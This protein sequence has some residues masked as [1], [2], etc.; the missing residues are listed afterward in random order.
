[1][2]AIVITREQLEQADEDELLTLVAYGYKPA[3]AMLN[4]RKA[5]KAAKS[6]ID[7]ADHP[8]HE[9]HERIVDHY[10]P[11]IQRVMAQSI[12][13]IDEAVATAKRKYDAEQDATKAT[14]D[15]PKMTAAQRAA[16]AA[17]EAH[18]TVNSKNL[19]ELMHQLL[20][21]G[22]VSAGHATAEDVGGKMLWGLGEEL[23]SV[24][25]ATWEPGWAK[26]ADL[27]RGGGLARLLETAKATV[28]DMDANTLRWL[29]NVLA[30]GLDAGSSSVEIARAMDEV[31][32]N[33]DRALL[34][35]NTEVSRAMSEATVDTYAANDI[36]QWEW[37]SEQDERTCDFC[38]DKDGQQYDVGGDDPRPPEHPRCRCV[39]LPVV[40]EPTQEEMDAANGTGGDDT[41][42]ADEE[43]G[44][45]KS[46]A[47]EWSE[48]D[49]PRGPDGRFGATD[50]ETTA[51][52]RS[53]AEATI[54]QAQ[55][56]KT[57]DDFAQ[58]AVTHEQL[59]D[60]H[61]KEAASMNRAA[62]LARTNGQR[63]TANNLERTALEHRNAADRHDDAASRWKAA[64]R[65]NDASSARSATRDAYMRTADVHNSARSMS[66][67][68]NKIA[69]SET[70]ETSG[71]KSAVGPSAPAGA[72]Y[73]FSSMDDA[74]AHFEALGI[75]VD[76]VGLTRIGTTPE[77]MA[78]IANA[79]SDMN[80]KYPGVVEQLDR[81]QA[82][83]SPSKG[84]LAAVT[85][86]GPTALYVTP[87]GCRVASDRDYGTAVF[88]VG[89]KFLNPE[90]TMLTASMRDVYYHEMGHVLQRMPVGPNGERSLSGTL[91]SYRDNN[92]PHVE[93]LRAAG[94]ITE[95]GN[96]R[97]GQIT[98][99]LAEYASTDN[100]EF[101]SEVVALFNHPERF[102]RL[103]EEVQTKLLAYQ[104]TL[105]E[106]VG[107]NVLK[108]EADAETPQ[109][110]VIDEHWPI[111][112]DAIN[113][114]YG[115]DD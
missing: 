90:G 31:V 51:N 91:S 5:T 115:Y 112:W 93:A 34:I 7:W 103:P 109:T 38:L 110:N 105:N 62:A 53:Q 24:D 30:D 77:H 83:P 100:L 75:S 49:H 65:S 85:V 33:P 106:M 81:I 50:M 104:T 98:K 73:K 9:I 88:E 108:A 28:K 101:H 27:T 82:H 12:R 59:R 71:F 69:A 56:A 111:D 25:W 23:T 36:E 40:A 67:E 57:T 107:T 4:K 64:V 63:A 76:A 99:D 42:E 22:I 80:E 41:E 46:L 74:V 18:I 1:M 84:V 20:A 114:K 79:V 92:N 47:K 48:D 16:Q 97:Y 89:S 45:E 32:D 66:E 54:K 96:L 8:Y 58:V 15:T 44:T 37:L 10:K 68:E 43:V 29:G 60:S 52:L 113:R 102:N 2:T 61:T 14:G 86:S 3:L 55:T 19:T 39:V 17:V 72:N 94:Y 6:R 13:G 70:R 26:A 11:K 87:Y 95:S 21:D 35:A 78:T